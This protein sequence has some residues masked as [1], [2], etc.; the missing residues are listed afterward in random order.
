MGDK[1][2]T[3]REQ[4]NDK[5]PY[6]YTI[7]AFCNRWKPFILHAIKVDGATRFSRF[8]KQLPISEKVLADNLKELEA[9]ELITKNVYPEVPPRVEYCL[10]EQGESACRVLDMMYDWG[11]HEMKRRGLEVDIIG[12]MWH[13]YREK[14][15]ELLDAPYKE[16]NYRQKHKY[17]NE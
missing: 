5:D 13:G 16:Y 3:E 7:R 10:T 8:C 11:W 4:F 1:K 2:I 14:D 6:N 17:D 12:E 15:E 9:D